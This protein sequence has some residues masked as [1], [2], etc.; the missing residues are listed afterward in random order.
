MIALSLFATFIYLIGCDAKGSVIMNCGAETDQMKNVVLSATPDP[1]K[2][3]RRFT[4]ELSGELAKDLDAG[5]IHVDLSLTMRGNTSSIDR[6]TPFKI[7][8]GIPKGPVTFKMGPFKFPKFP[9]GVEPK[10]NGTLSFL[11]DDG[12]PVNCL[13]FNQFPIYSDIGKPVRIERTSHQTKDTEKSLQLK[14]KPIEFCMDDD[15]HIQDL[16]VGWT[17]GISYINGTLNEKLGDFDLD[18]EIKITSV[19]SQFEDITITIDIDSPVLIAPIIP[20]GFI[21]LQ[22][23]PSRNNKPEE[24][25]QVTGTVTALKGELKIDDAFD[26]EVFCLKWDIERDPPNSPELN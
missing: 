3:G 11:N 14:D 19:K 17:K 7:M 2:A 10:V 15:A 6:I 26:E 25:V 5:F 12:R 21:G 9:L 24:D 18:L 1:P 20:K 16:K 23:G 22:L 4:L 8:P 13:F